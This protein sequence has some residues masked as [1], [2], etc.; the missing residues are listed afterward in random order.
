MTS[1]D[2]A[3][4]KERT[5]AFEQQISQVREEHKQSQKEMQDMRERVTGLEIRTKKE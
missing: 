2:F 1:K 3:A 4:L 5:S